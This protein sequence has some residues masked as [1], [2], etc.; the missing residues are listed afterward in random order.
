MNTTATVQRRS[1]PRTRLV[2]LFATLCLLL[3]ACSPAAAEDGPIKIGTSLPLTGQISQ[4]GNE[5]KRGYEVWAELVNENGGLLGRP[6]QLII[7]DDASDQNTVVSDYNA[8]ISSDRVD[9]L[10]GTYT[11]LLNLPASAIAERNKK[12]FVEPAGG[13]PQMFNRGFRYLFFTQ[14]AMADQSGV[15]FANWVANLPPDQRPKTAAYPSIDDPF[16]E[17]AVAAMRG[18]L[19]QAGIQTVY[20]ST[21]A[22]DTRNFDTIAAGLKNSN[23]DLVV[24]G[25]GFED[26]VGMVRAMR[27]ANVRPKLLYQMG[28]PGMGEQYAQAIGP[29]NTEGI[30]FS[31]SHTPDAATSGNAEFVNR[32]RQKYNAEPPEDAAEAFATGQVIQAAVQGAGDVKDQTAMADWLRQNSVETVLGK[33]SWNDNGSPNGSFPIGQ[34]QGGKVKLVLPEPTAQSPVIPGWRPGGQ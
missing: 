27:T 26:G 17:P 8:L 24:H 14:Q 29:E 31:V 18:I 5:A 6:V 20:E 32:Y 13:S 30:F 16:A 19:E 25:A 11:S 23:P 21:Y 1:W 2:A 15:A 28:A 12:L 3:A 4:P 33:L 7:K 34:W 10:A 22:I 9:L